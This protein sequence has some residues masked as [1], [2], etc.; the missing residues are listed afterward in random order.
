MIDFPPSRP[1]LLGLVVGLLIGGVVGGIV[2]SSDA[3]APDASDP[4]TSYTSVGPSCYDGPRANDGWL[5]VVA[6]GEAWTTTLN[7]TVVHPRGTEVDVDVVR[8]ST[9]TYEIALRTTE[10]DRGKSLAEGCRAES[11]LTVAT[12]LSAP[13]FVV[14]VD[15]RTVRTVEQ[16]ETVPTLY[17]LPNPIEID[18]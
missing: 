10:T 18:E 2:M 15:G 17:P 6:N 3:S 14:T 7:A 5:H 4:P 1:L 9:D 13:D 12:A 8:R 16:D 11:R